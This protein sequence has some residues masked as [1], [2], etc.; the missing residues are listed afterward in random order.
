M[1]QYL[2]NF[3]RTLHQSFTAQSYA[4]PGL[5]MQADQNGMCC[6]LQWKQLRS[7]LDKGVFVPLSGDKSPWHRWVYLTCTTCSS[8]ITSTGLTYVD[9]AMGLGSG[10]DLGFNDCYCTK[11]IHTPS[12]SLSVLPL[13]YP[14]LPHPISS[15]KLSSWQAFSGQCSVWSQSGLTTGGPAACSLHIA[16][17]PFMM[18]IKKSPPLE[19]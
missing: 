5:P 4:S 12:H 11:P 16:S 9:L 14:P 1:D 15:A 18:A 19:G 8:E 7:S 2:K 10:S 6:I 3:S 17:R 13:F